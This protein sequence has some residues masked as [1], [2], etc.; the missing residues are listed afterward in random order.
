VTSDD[1]AR[2]LVHDV[3][4][5]I[6]EAVSDM[7]RYC[8]AHGEP[9]TRT[10]LVALNSLPLRV[11]LGMD[12]SVQLMVDTYDAIRRLMPELPVWPDGPDGVDAWLRRQPTETKH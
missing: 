3:S 1:F 2:T 9:L 11:V 6:V 12:E 4:D 5:R 7:R 8:D 10:Q